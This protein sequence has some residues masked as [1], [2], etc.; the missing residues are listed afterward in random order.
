MKG[1]RAMQY[2]VV[3]WTDYF[4]DDYPAREGCPEVDRAVIAELREKGYKFDGFQHQ[5]S[6]NCAPVLNDGTKVL[7]SMREWGAIMAEALN[8]DNSD[9]KAYLV[10]YAMHEDSVFPPSDDDDN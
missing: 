10:W 5:Y 2:K 6:R 7:Y 3:G 9:G 4:E 1:D 8:I